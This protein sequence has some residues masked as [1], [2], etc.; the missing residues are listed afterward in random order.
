MEIKSN[1]NG[2]SNNKIEDKKQKESSLID[3]NGNNKNTKIDFNE[4]EEAQVTDKKQGFSFI[5]QQQPIQNVTQSNS[6]TSNLIDLNSNTNF[7]DQKFN[8]A[9]SDIFK[10]YNNNDQNVP[11]NTQS[12]LGIHNP[13][14]N[15]NYNSFPQIHIQ[16][17]FYNPNIYNG[18]NQQYPTMNSNNNQNM[19]NMMYQQQQMMNNQN[20]QKMNQV[21]SYDLYY[22]G[23]KGN[24]FQNN[25]QQP[26]NNNK[27]DFTSSSSNTKTNKEKQDPF[28][29]LVNFK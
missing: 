3:L 16:N 19:Q 25:N 7:K 17:T 9:T 6:N 13:T 20:M 8:E 26:F 29:S 21:S 2:I 27:I 23:N 11:N 12:N 1:N 5:K 18:Y 10:L 24:L 4:F 22:N 14:N 28:K 15:V